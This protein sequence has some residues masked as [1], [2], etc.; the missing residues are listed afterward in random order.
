[1]RGMSGMIRERKRTPT[2]V[3][4]VDD[5]LVE[6]LW[7]RIRR[8]ASKVDIVVR[9]CKRTHDQGEKVDEIFF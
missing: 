7:V 3:V 1:M 6:S 4:G 8:Q 2:Y 5:M 9:L